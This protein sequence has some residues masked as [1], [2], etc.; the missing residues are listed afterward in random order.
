MKFK[1]YNDYE[2]HIKKHYGNG[3]P[4]GVQRSIEKLMV[5][6]SFNTN[7]VTHR[8]MDEPEFLASLLSNN[9]TNDSE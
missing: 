5:P 4:C 3:S 7:G 1:S 8:I 6:K 9:T 2:K